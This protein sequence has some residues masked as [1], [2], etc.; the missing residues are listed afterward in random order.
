MAALYVVIFHARWLMW[1]G[2]TEGYAR[3]PELYGL[4]AKLIAYG[5]LVFYYGHQA[6]IF[7]FVLSGFVIHLRYA[8]QLQTEP[9][10]GFDFLPYLVRR[11][12]RL[13]PVLLA[14][15][16]LT[17]I[18]DRIGRAAGFS[19]YQSNTLY[20]L[21][22]DVRPAFD[23]GRLLNGIA[24]IPVAPE[25]G[26]NLP[27]WSL[28]YEWA[29]YLVYPLLWFIF[30]RSMKWATILLGVLCGL[31]FIPALWP[32]EALRRV[33]ALMIVWWF[34]AILA[35]I[36]TGRIQIKLSKIAPLVGLLLILPFSVEPFFK[37]DETLRDVL[38]GLAFMGGL[39]TFLVWRNAGR[40]L[41]LL[42]RLEGL[43][44][45]SYTLYAIHFPILF[46]LS[47]W[48]IS[49]SVDGSLPQTYEWIVIGTLV[50]LLSAWLLHFVVERPFM[51]KRRL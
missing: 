12:R 49:R 26:S 37:M 6:V 8:R 15:L 24:L 31:S 13:Y 11:I 35:E 41:R 30:R 2:F 10:K 46:L 51:G 3:H 45:F 29:F 14:T 50:C 27:L 48:L 23:F 32:L 43:G 7:F 40:S 1:E 25:W 38:W 9:D 33:A 22:N 18:L 28:R 20:G 4:P 21:I 19:V 47:G 17:F 36:Y 16:A 5:S 42:E 34:G 39:A 44:K